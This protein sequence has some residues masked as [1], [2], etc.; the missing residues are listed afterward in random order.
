MLGRITSAIFLNERS[1]AEGCVHREAAI[2]GDRTLPSV[3]RAEGQ[4]A[5]TNSQS[6]KNRQENSLRIWVKKRRNAPHIRVVF[7]WDAAFGSMERCFTA[8]V[9]RKLFFFTVSFLPSRVA[10]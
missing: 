8:L 9:K 1:E 2:P 3:Q 6:R 5:D 10:C 4:A 7:V